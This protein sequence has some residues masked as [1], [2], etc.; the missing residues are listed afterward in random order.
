MDIAFHYP[1]SKDKSVKH[2]ILN[3]LG[4]LA[5]GCVCKWCF[6]TIGV[7]SIIANLA[8]PPCHK[9]SR[10]VNDCAC[11]SKA[12]VR[13]TTLR[14]DQNST[15]SSAT[16]KLANK[17]MTLRWPIQPALQR[18]QATLWRLLLTPRRPPSWIVQPWL[19][20]SRLP[21]AYH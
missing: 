12:S 16:N 8:Q 13:G 21:V 10:E 7:L 15:V 4:K 3:G 6:L 18:H 2:E 14:L 9:L 19:V 20:W 1:K 11:S 5:C 17:C